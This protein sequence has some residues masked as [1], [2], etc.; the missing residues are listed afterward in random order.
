MEL[1]T[2]QLYGLLIF[3]CTVKYKSKL[4]LLLAYFF[5][6]L[7]FCGACDIYY[8]VLI[9]PIVLIP[10][11]PTSV[12]SLQPI[13]G[14]LYGAKQSAWHN[15]PAVS[16][17][18]QTFI[19]LFNF[20]ARPIVPH[21]WFSSVNACI[22]SGEWKVQGTSAVSHIFQFEL[23]TSGLY[24]QHGKGKEGFARLHYSQCL[25]LC[26]VLMQNQCNMLRTS[27]NTLGPSCIRLDQCKQVWCLKDWDK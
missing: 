5:S 2:E 18:D 8:F 14:L 21:F 24:R 1:C 7:F 16:R 19:Y 13:F 17:G 25:T 3:P 10:F 4:S 15:L 26:S 20:S 27:I 11:F 6:F 9:V 22:W 23:L 12:L